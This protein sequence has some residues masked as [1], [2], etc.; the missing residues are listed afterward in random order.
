LELLI[1]FVPDLVKNKLKASGCSAYAPLNNNFKAAGLKSK[2]H[3]K[4]ELPERLYS[5]IVC[6]L[7]CLLKLVDFQAI[8][9]FYLN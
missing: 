5:D 3:A 4:L 2:L 8:I 7:N 9:E 6:C 1:A